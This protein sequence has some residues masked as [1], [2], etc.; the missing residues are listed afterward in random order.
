MYSLI[1]N[2]QLNE[3]FQ[4]TESLDEELPKS[5]K[6]G[7]MPLL[8]LLPAIIPKAFLLLASG[9]PNHF[10]GDG[11]PRRE[12]D[13]RRSRWHRARVMSNVECCSVAGL[14]CAL[15]QDDGGAAI[16]EDNDPGRR[17]ESRPR[18]KLG[19]PGSVLDIRRR[20]RETAV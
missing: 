5:Q 19:L 10:P 7:I 17:I 1:T 20:E 9:N 4:K 6:D 3:I 15:P 2:A 14:R 12:A 18:K 8:A 16:P 13:E 11:W